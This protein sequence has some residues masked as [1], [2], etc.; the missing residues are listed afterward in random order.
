MDCPVGYVVYLEHVQDLPLRV[1]PGSGQ[2][3]G[4]HDCHAKWRAEEVSFGSVLDAQLLVQVQGEGE[5]EVAYTGRHFRQMSANSEATHLR[6]CYHSGL[7][8]DTGGK[9]N[10]LLGKN[11]ATA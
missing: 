10:V 2:R 3:H 6:F 1:V 11:G 7:S 9:G 5:E 4:Q 8:H